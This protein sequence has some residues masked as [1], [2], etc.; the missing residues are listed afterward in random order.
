MKR[1]LV[2]SALLIVGRH[3]DRRGAADETGDRRSEGL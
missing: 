1:T 3:R 2:L